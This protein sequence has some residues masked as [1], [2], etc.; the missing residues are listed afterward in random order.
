MVRGVFFDLGGTLFSYAGL[1]AGKLLVEA[2]GR[3]GITEEPRAIGKAYGLA[4]REVNAEFAERPYYLHRD[5]F[6]GIY[7]NFVERLGGRF[8]E[9][10]FEWYE[11]RNR[12]HIVASLEVKHDCTKTLDTLKQRSLYLS[13]VSNID[14]DMLHP[15]VEREGLHRWLDHWTSSEEARSC[16]PHA[17]FFELA[18]EKSGL[19]PDEVLFV[20]DSPEHDVQGAHDAGMRTVLVRTQDA[21]APPLQVG[22]QTVAPDHEI[23]DL[24]ELAALVSS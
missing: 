20:G 13:I 2:A 4:S 21:P 19:A 7:R 14:D 15:L 8:S 10:E 1:A 24:A 23:T 6:A 22:R 18:L 17:Q 9:A 11:E 3:A 12:E 16:K 5:L